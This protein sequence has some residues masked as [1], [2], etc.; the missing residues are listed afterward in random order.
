MNLSKLSI[1]ILIICICSTSLLGKNHF[2]KIND[3]IS[4]NLSGRVLDHA[5]ESPLSGV[6]VFLIDDGTVLT[7]TDD[8]GYFTLKNIPLGHQTLQIQ[9]MGYK[10]KIVPNILIKAGNTPFIEIMLKE[11]L[12]TLSEVVLSSKVSEDSKNPVNKLA[13]VSAKIFNIQSVNKYSGGRLDVARMVRNFAGVA[14][15]DDSRNDIVIRGNSPTGVLWKLNGVPIPNPNH[16]ASAG[17]TGGSVSALNTNFLKN[18]DFMTGAF[19]AEYGNSTAGVFDVNFREG[20]KSQ[21][22]FT[23][24]IHATGGFEGLLEGPIDSENKSSYVIGYRH[25]VTSTG[26]VPSSAT[27]T[28]AVP[29]Y[30]DLTFNI[31]LGKSR[32]Y[33][34]FNFFGI[35]GLSNI[36][37]LGKEVDSKD[38]FANADEDL[39]TESKLGI[40]GLSHKIF[41]SKDT[42]LYTVLMGAY[43]GNGVT[44][45]KTNDKSIAYK[46][47]EQNDDVSAFTLSSVL[48]T[49][50]NSNTT[51]RSGIIVENKSVNSF[52]ESNYN[53]NPK[54][55]KDNNK[56]GIP[57][58]IK[59]VDFSGNATLLQ[60][61]SEMKYRFSNELTLNTGIHSQYYQ[62]NNDYIFEPRIG[63][64]WQLEEKQSL[65]I[66]YGLHS[67]TQPLNI[68]L[69]EDPY[70]SNKQTNKNLSFGKSNHFVLGYD[71]SISKD[72]HLKSEAYFQ[73]LLDIPISKDDINSYSVLNE[74]AD[75]R[76]TRKNN[77]VNK[78][79]GKNYGLELTIEKYFTHNSYLM[80]TSSIFDSKYKGSDDVE[81]NTA[82]NNKY[83]ANILAGKEFPVALWSKEK[84]NTFLINLKVTTAGGRYY[85]PIDLEATK[86]NNGDVVYKDDLAFSERYDPYFRTDFR[87]G[88]RA[89]SKEYN[90]TQE[91]FI[92]LLNVGNYQNIFQK[93]YNTATQEINDVY[94]LGLFVDILYRIQF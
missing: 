78:G 64:S 59:F 17:T 82:F 93:K 74:G 83:V 4:Q 38:L 40:V 89:N 25:A 76:F 15:T 20:N 27:G 72:W 9:Q 35:L 67:Q 62:F 22:K 11:D 37:F 5:S 29:N 71:W 18:S 46:A 86:I 65:S 8:D 49:K 3:T 90:I 26:L 32:K 73:Y 84:V 60:A 2:S 68:L 85:T 79:T 88:F 10:Q 94:Q 57:D 44:I 58:L 21:T 16:F 1:F 43:T 56:D 24:Q 50:I 34:S 80:F 69:L 48:N 66:A 12:T 41:L 81:R 92:D 51:I 13:T 45:D 7:E 75:F 63:L 55:I 54:L 53:I 31:T 42:Y 23:G 33:G 52:L 28:N 87:V 91:W 36:D 39:S 30:K 14:N 70:Q 61:F 77:L 6:V 47:V 19:P